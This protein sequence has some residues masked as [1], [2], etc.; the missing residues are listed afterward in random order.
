MQNIEF[1]AEL[2]DIEAARQQCRLVGAELHQAMRQRDTYFRM[3]DGRL[4][5]R[6]IDG[7]RIQWVYYHR[8]D[9]VSPRMSNYT[10]LTDVQAKRRWGTRNLKPWLM[11][12][13]SRELWIVDDVRIHLDDV[14]DL[15]T[16][17]EF[18]ALV[19]RRF[20]VKA[21][22]EAI[23]RLREAFM[24]LMGEPISVSYSDLL[25]VQIT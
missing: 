11:V 3:A 10:L 6:E 12:E 2:R 25:Q 24:P 4:K 23:A 8:P 22:H 15:G 21:C 9:R 16:F 1:K 20:N 19:S 14:K 18:E 13:K 7:K 17:I 5:K